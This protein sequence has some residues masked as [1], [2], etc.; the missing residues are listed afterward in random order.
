HRRTPVRP[1][2]VRTPPHRRFAVM[3][4]EVL[5][6][7]RQERLADASTPPVRRD[8]QLSH[9]PVPEWDHREALVFG[10]RLDP[11][12]GKADHPGAILSDE[13]QPA[14]ARSILDHLTNQLDARAG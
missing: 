5:I 10:A 12:A 9:D 11:P 6:H 8:V 2:S 7:R 4:P 3:T 1:G 14:R 13:H